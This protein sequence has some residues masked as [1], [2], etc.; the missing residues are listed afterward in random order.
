MARRSSAAL[1]AHEVGVGARGT[2]ARRTPN[3]RRRPPFPVA[4]PGA[5]DARGTPPRGQ[6]SRRERGEGIGPFFGRLEAA[7]ARQRFPA[8]AGTVPDVPERALAEQEEFAGRRFFP[9]RAL[10]CQS[11]GQERGRRSR[12]RLW[13]FRPPRIHF[14]RCDASAAGVRRPEAVALRASSAPPPSS[15]W[16]AVMSGTVSNSRTAPAPFPACSFSSKQTAP[17]HGESQ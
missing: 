4:A 15:S 14:P 10:V 9:C 8:R 7:F 2:A 16:R 17:E 3:L 13:V 11:L 1:S 6:R 12:C 5:R